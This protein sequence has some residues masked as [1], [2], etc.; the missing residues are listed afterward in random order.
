MNLNTAFGR[1]KKAT[2]WQE[3]ILDKQI[4]ANPLFF[5]QFNN[6]KIFI[7][8]YED[9][10]FNYRY[11]FKQEGYYSPFIA[12]LFKKETID[13]IK[14]LNTD[15]YTILVQDGMGFVVS[16]YNNSEYLKNDKILFELTNKKN[17]D[18]ITFFQLNINKSN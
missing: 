7:M 9:S 3:D 10:Y 5:D 6:R 1:L 18:N 8:S 4:D 15:G 17:L 13:L 14:K 12:N 2:L 16:E 11:D